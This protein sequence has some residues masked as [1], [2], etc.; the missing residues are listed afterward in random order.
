[1]PDIENFVFV[2][3]LDSQIARNGRKLEKG[4]S[5]RAGD[6]P[7]HVVKEWIRTN[8]AKRVEE[9]SKGKEKD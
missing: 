4:Q 6:F 3:L 5:Y 2:W 7:A 8:A 1:M 9:K